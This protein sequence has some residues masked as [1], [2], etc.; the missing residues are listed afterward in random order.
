[1]NFTQEFSISS[2]PLTKY[3]NLPKEFYHEPTPLVPCIF[4]FINKYQCSSVFIKHISEGLD[5]ATII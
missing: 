3:V 4:Y 2:I 5:H 1:M